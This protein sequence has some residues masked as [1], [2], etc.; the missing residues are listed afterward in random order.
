VPIHAVSAISHTDTSASADPTAKY[1][2]VG[3]NCRQI[4]FTA[5]A[6]RVYSRFK[7]GKLIKLL[8]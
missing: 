4:T 5:W 3:S 1:L 8:K 2:P 7:F 6:F